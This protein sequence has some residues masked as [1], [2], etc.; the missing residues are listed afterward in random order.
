MANEIMTFNHTTVFKNPELE[1]AT[2]RIHQ[3][4]TTSL[5]GLRDVA[6]AMHEIHTKSLYK[7]D[8]FQNLQEYAEKTFGFKKSFAYDM[9]AAGK[10][11]TKSLTLPAGDNDHGEKPVPLDGFSVS[12]LK[13]CQKLSDEEMAHAV[14][15]GQIHPEMTTKEIRD[16]VN[17]IHPP[18]TRKAKEEP[19]SVYCFYNPTLS[20]SAHCTKKELEAGFKWCHWFTQDGAEYVAVCSNGTFPIVLSYTKF[21]PDQIEETTTEETA[22]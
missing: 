10:L 8:G 14:A 6:I 5:N 7:D 22:E 9:V 3:A 1:K 18:K 21:N 16:Y 12:Q 11:L 19:E 13:E 15:D 20:T 2:I 4:Y 17:T